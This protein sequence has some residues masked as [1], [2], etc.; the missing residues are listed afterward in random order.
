MKIYSLAT[1][2]NVA[3][4]QTE[5]YK[6]IYKDISDVPTK[7]EDLPLVDIDSY[8]SKDPIKNENYIFTEKIKDGFIYASS[9]S[10]GLPKYTA[11]SKQEWTTFSQIMGQ[12]MWR[13]QIFENGDI[14][15]NL[16]SVGDLL[17]SFLTVHDGLIS[18]I[19][20]CVELPI[21]ISSTT[22][23]SRIVDMCRYLKVNAIVGLSFNLM[24]I[25][26]YVKENKITDLCLTKVIYG[27]ETMHEEQLNLIKEAFPD[28]I[29]SPCI[30]SSNDAGLV[31]FWDSTCLYN[32]LKSC[33][34]YVKIE[35]I[36]E[37]TKM[38]ISE[39]FEE[40]NVYVT[41]F[42]KLLMP[43]IR[44]PV[45]DKGMWVDNAII[46]RKLTISG[47]LNQGEVEIRNILFS[48]EKIIK[49]INL[50]FKK[51]NLA[52]F[53]LD[54]FTEN[55]RDSLALRLGCYNKRKFTNDDVKLVEKH[56]F[57]AFPE[58]YVL[59]KNSEINPIEIRFVELDEIKANV[60]PGKHK[61]V[62]DNRN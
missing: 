49:E 45:G 15:A 39:P 22:P 47:R 24:D 17:S 20:E 13:S 46:N 57:D 18:S 27:G 11:F 14:I 29:V 34:P 21:S 26:Y 36:N 12:L 40:G 51:F 19:A 42:T 37:Q 43:I 41:N 55:S 48:K 60:G 9:G 62:V 16:A 59:V 33:D 31:G 28:A 44:Y 53:Q 5:Y 61:Q 38:P 7:L 8:W 2:F 25:A 10:S 1:L 6:K 35:I 52:R 54:I 4:C 32:E 56:L 3:R 23:I 30:Y 58:L 50:V